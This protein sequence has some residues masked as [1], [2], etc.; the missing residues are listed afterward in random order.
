MQKQKQKQTQ[1]SKQ[2]KNVGVRSVDFPWDSKPSHEQQVIF[3][4]IPKVIRQLS[5][6]TALSF[7]LRPQI[8]SQWILDLTLKTETKQENMRKKCAPDLGGRTLK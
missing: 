3:V 2:Q 1:K 5:I 8:F 7:L 4:K 6:K